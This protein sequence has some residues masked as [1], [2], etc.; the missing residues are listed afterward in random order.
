MI[1]LFPYCWMCGETFSPRTV[2][3]RAG[4][5]FDAKDEPGEIARSGRYRD[6]PNP[7]GSASID[8]VHDRSSCDPLS[9][10][11]LNFLAENIPI[12]R[13]AGAEDIGIHCDVDYSD[14]CN[15]A[16]SPEF[17]VAVASLG[18]PLSFSCYEDDTLPDESW[19]LEED[20]STEP[21]T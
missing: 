2:E 12:F 4:I 13:E 16:M 3:R 14:Q 9:M 19:E 8:F 11:S 10:E 6:Q 21:Q 15:L 18:V 5:V 7:H 1:R 20:D 17:L